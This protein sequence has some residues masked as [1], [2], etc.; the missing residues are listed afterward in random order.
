MNQSRLKD[1]IEALLLV[2]TEPLP[3]PTLQGILHEYKNEEIQTA[4]AELQ[5]QYAE[6]E[7]GIQINQA[8]GGFYFTTNPLYDEYVKR[9]LRDEKKAKLS[10]AALE[11]LS[12]VAY[13]QPI[14]QAEISA[15]RG[16]DASHSLRTLLHKKLVKIIGRKKSP[17]NP[18]IYRTS[19][20][21][22][23]Y[24]GLDSLDDLPT[25]EEI[26]KIIEIESD[27]E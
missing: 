17:G 25:Q 14:T 8:S 21:F 22:L 26:E 23:I 24:F 18:L 5:A 15:I 9:F 10:H 16:V 19:K 20:R 7:K 12:I 6:D 27:D 13:H 4:L 2:A 11:T 1:I 3:L